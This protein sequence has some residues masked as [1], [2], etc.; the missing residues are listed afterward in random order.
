MVVGQ[1]SL[2]DLGDGGSIDSGDRADI[3]KRVQNNQ[4]SGQAMGPSAAGI[5]ASGLT[6]GVEFLE[7]PGETIKKVFP[8]H[9]GKMERERAEQ[10]ADQA[11]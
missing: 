4:E 2:S 10:N 1:G 9:E 5:G 11:E 7:K 3:E 6:K 8:G